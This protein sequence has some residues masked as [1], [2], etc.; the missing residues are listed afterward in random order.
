MDRFRARPVVRGV[1]RAFLGRHEMRNRTGVRLRGGT[2][3][4][5]RGG[6]MAAVAP[7]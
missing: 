3:T 6:D 2:S 5:S 1:R 7:E 4:G